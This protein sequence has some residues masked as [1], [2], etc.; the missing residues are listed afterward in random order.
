MTDHLVFNFRERTEGLKVGL[1][2]ADIDKRG[3]VRRRI[4]SRRKDIVVVVKVGKR[5]DIL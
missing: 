1:I 2:L 3:D 5:R 4:K